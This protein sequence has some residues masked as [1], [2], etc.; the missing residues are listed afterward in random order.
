M[1]N[2]KEVSERIVAERKAQKVK[3]VELAKLAG[4]SQATL[5]HIERGYRNQGVTISIFFRIILALG[6]DFNYAMTGKRNIYGSDL[7]NEA[8]AFAVRFQQLDKDKRQ[9]L[10]SILSVFEGVT[11]K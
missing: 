11:K 4:V 1:I 2:M 9:A 3:Q 10:S 5:C 7:S 8:N 6:M